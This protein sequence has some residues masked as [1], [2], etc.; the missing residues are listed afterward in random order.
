MPTVSGRTVGDIGYG[1]IPLSRPPPPPEDQSFSVLRNCISTGCT[2][3]DGGEHYGKPDNNSLTLLNRYFERYPED[4]AK[5]TLCIKGAFGGPSMLPDCSPEGVRRSVDNC[6][7]LLGPKGRI[8]MFE[9]S[10]RDV[11]V[12]LE[13]TMSTLA[14]LVEEGKI[15]GVALSEVNA[16]SIRASAKVAKI[17]AVEIELSLWCRDPMFNGITDACARLGIPILAYCPIGRGMLTGSIKT[18]DD[19]PAQDPRRVFP[20][21]SPENFNMNLKLVQAVEEVA[22]RKGCTPAQLAIGWLRGLSKRP[23]MPEIIPIPGTSNPARVTENASPAKLSE[24]EML[25]IDDLLSKFEIA[26]DR[27]PERFMSMTNL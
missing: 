20:R 15:G 1:M 18:L 2:L 25:E 14:A 4:A 11:N 6:V 16:E 24:Q 9:C 13:S 21:F 10:R 22:R 12:P 5:I 27:Y 3:W 17:V 8:D 23:G 19:L 7:K 26:G